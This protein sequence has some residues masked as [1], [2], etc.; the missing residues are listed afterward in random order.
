[1]VKKQ[2]NLPAAIRSFTGY[3]E[4]TEKAAHTIKSYK[5]DLLAFQ[6]YLH[7]AKGPKRA[8]RLDALTAKDLDHY[9][10][11]MTAAGLKT[12]TR[13]RKLMTLRKFLSYLAGRRKISVDLG[14]TLLTPSKVERVPATLPYDEL[15]EAVRALPFD[16]ELAARNRALLWT[17]VETGCLVSEVTRLRYDQYEFATTAST[18]AVPARKSAAGDLRRF[19]SPTKESAHSKGST[20]IGLA[21][22][23]VEFLSRGEARRVPVSRELVEA[24]RDLRRISRNPDHPW[25]YIGFNKFGPMSGA[26]MTPRGVE[27]L[28]R[29]LAPRLPSRG[30]GTSAD[31]KRGPEVEVTPRI[32]RHSTVRY[33]L[34]QGIDRVEIQR[35]L[36]LK[37][38]YAFRTFEPLL[39]KKE[40]SGGKSADSTD[41]NRGRNKPTKRRN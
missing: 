41:S 33:W 8:Q 38:A 34:D 13:R 12:N 19:K 40:R 6:N 18:S 35:R 29:A 1:M 7:E 39:K 11:H 10:A 23:T 30:A 26:P 25:A 22:G 37:T 20:A 15:L 21:G 2:L 31:S 32:L 24:L 27:L 5:L 3:L 4:G 14:K 36:G 17:L 28:V 9:H 16:T